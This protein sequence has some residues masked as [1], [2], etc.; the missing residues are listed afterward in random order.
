MS[1][2]RRCASRAWHPAVVLTYQGDAE[3]F[4]KA[5]PERWQ[6]FFDGMAVGGTCVRCGAV[7]LPAS[8]ECA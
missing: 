4:A 1:I 8:F 7:A 5:P 6:D 2:R 3:T